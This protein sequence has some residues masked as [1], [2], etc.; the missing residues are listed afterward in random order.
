MIRGFFFHPKDIK[1][2]PTISA[3][4]WRCIETVRQGCNSNNSLRKNC[5]KDVKMHLKS[6][7]SLKKIWLSHGKTVILQHENPPSLF[8]MLKSAGRFILLWHDTQKHIH[9]QHNWYRCCNPV[10]FSLRMR[11]ELR[12]IFAT[13][14]ITDSV[15]ISILFWPHRRRTMYSSPVP[16]SIKP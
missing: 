13:L 1:V 8:T 10:D 9:H 5:K 14:A 12:I 2:Q 6:A 7:F 16:R 11:H 4:H 3:E 15:L